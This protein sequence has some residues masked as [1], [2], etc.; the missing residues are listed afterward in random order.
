MSGRKNGVATAPSP[1]RPERVGLLFLLVGAVAALP[2]A[3]AAQEREHINAVLA[4]D[5]TASDRVLAVLRST[6]DRQGVDL[7]AVSADRIDPLDVARCPLDRSP[8]GPV[9]HLWLDL[10]AGP[11]AMYLLD[12]R[13]GLVYV[14]PLAVHPDPD[15]VELE[16]IRLVVDSSV[17]AILK[18]RALGV[19]RDEFERSLAPAPVACG[20]GPGFGS[21]HRYREPS[22]GRVGLGKGPPRGWLLSR[23]FTSRESLKLCVRWGFRLY[24]CHNRLTVLGL[25]C[26]ARAMVRQLQ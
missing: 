3:G 13:S 7:V 16:L 10:T 8:T 4:G 26:C 18:G 23:K 6:L 2:R 21:S 5:P 15:V 12:V 14:R 25:T 17:E 20:P 9:A 24:S 11:P 22:S 19:S 1:A